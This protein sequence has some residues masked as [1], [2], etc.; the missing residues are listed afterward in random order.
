[1][2]T[3]PELEIKQRQEG[4]VIVLELRGQLVSDEDADA[5]DQMLQ[6]LIGR[7]CL[8]LLLDCGQ[9]SAFDGSGIKPMVRAHISMLKREG[10]LKLLRV[11]ASMRETLASVNLMSA[12]QAF[13]DEKKALQ[14]F[15]S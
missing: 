11:P 5:L 8:A 2:V 14:S 1:V 7:G 6:A 9:V 4:G 13:D 3:V 10:T 12:L 15:G